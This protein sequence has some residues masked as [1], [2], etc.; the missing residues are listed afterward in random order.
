MG[1]T[2]DAML[3]AL[4]SYRH[5]NPRRFSGVVAFVTTMPFDPYDR[6]LREDGVHRAFAGAMR[7]ATELGFTVE[8]FNLKADG[9]TPK[10]LCEI[11][12]A[13]NIQGVILA[14]IPVPGEF[15]VMDWNDFSVVA[16][17]FSII[18]PQLYRACLDLG[19]LTR[20]HMFELSRL[21]YQR[22]GFI[23][24][25]N[26]HLRTA[27]NYLGAY[28]CAQLA[29]P[30]K[31]R[32]P[33][34]CLNGV[35]PHQETVALWLKKYRPE[36]VMITYPEMLDWIKA[37][38]FEVPRDIGVSKIS[39]DSISAHIAGIQEAYDL[40]GESAI[41]LVVSLIRAN[42]RGLPRH[43]SYVV[44][45]GRWIFQPTVRQLR[46]VK[47]VLFHSLADLHHWV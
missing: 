7:Q 24:S 36:C 14:P 34:V 16:L 18:R 21:G 27:A 17:G 40:L 13:R 4:A 39:L 22:I 32:I 9:M 25:A 10:R 15:P 5:F 42:E 8:A 3:S 2:H 19:E 12:R 45:G 38:G 20:L 37:C 44:V 35:G 29:F 1:Y 11:F 30:E 41:D 28:L 31:E 33:P 26:V 47:K 46:P 43:P 23:L 6:D